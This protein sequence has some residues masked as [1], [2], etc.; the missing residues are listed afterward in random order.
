MVLD[1]GSTDNTLEVL[2]A[3]ADP[4]LTVQCNGDNKGML[5]NMVNVMVCGKGT[6]LVFCTDKDYVD[7]DRITFFKNFLLQQPELNCG[8]CRLGAEANGGIS[9]FRVG[10]AAVRAVA[11]KSRHPT[12]LFFRASALKSMNFLE[13]FSNYEYVDLFPLD[14]ALAD[15]SILGH[16][17]IFG[18][19]LFSPEVA[20]QAAVHKSWTTSGNARSA[21]FSPESRLKLTINYSIH[22][23]KLGLSKK[24]LK[25][26]LS[27]LFIQGLNQSTRGYRSVM[28]NEALCN[29]YGMD[30][31][32][33]SG[34]EML[35]I[36]WRFYRRWKDSTRS[37][38][39]PGGYLFGQMEFHA[40]AQFFRTLWSRA[41]VAR[42]GA[43]SAVSV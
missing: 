22:A 20:I 23:C 41:R 13:L 19:P 27:S 12:G 35:Q 28:G 10:Y 14:F 34:V 31:R 38:W 5:H 26:L 4:R 37:L 2:R 16:S 43:S 18:E 29:H 9:V 11:F 40:L 1:N 24:Q 8:F 32:V 30:R 42:V 6:F 7:A 39:M 33:V 21:F 25:S 3:I 15:A 17:A 36:A